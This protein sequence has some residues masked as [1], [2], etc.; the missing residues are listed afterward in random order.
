MICY[1]R[2]SLKSFI[3]FEIEQQNQESVNFEKIVQRAVNAEAKA[4]LR[5]TIIV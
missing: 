2:E 5:S 1:F 4:S 3:K